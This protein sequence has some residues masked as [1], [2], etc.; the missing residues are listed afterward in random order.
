[1]NSLMRF[2]MFIWAFSKFKVP[3]IGYVKPKLIKLD[4]NEIIIKIPLKRR[5]KNH[6]NSMYFGALAVGADLA[7]GFHGFYHSQK[8]NLKNSIAFKSFTGQFLK[9]PE[10]DVYFT[11]TQGKEIESMVN[12]SFKKGERINKNITVTAYINPE[13]PEEVAKFILELSIKV[14][15]K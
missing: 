5:T 7:A 1:M 12:E 8:S 10:A 4:D 13:H 9:R 15:K 6:L 2:K 11:C 14:I 3:M